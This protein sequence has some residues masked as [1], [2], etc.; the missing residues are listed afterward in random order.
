MT[1]MSKQVNSS[2]DMRFP[3]TTNKT[4]ERSCRLVHIGYIGFCPYIFLMTTC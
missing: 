4:E 1:N 2:S 3:A